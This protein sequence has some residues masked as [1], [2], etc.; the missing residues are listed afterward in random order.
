[1]FKQFER[2]FKIEPENHLAFCLIIGPAYLHRASVCLDGLSYRL[3]RAMAGKC[4]FRVEERP[5]EPLGAKSAMW[6]SADI[7][8][9]RSVKRR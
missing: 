9:R 4:P 5:T 6:R 3:G 7:Q 1:M 8:P 2:L